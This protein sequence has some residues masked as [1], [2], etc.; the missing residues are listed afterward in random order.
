MII[1][2]NLITHPELN[3]IFY[4]CDVFVW[5]KTT[6]LSFNIVFDVELLLENYII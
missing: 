4:K 1:Y 3:V 6:F 5:I 2:L